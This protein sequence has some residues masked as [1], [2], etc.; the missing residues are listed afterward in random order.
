MGRTQG[1]TFLH[2]TVIGKKQV[3]ILHIAGFSLIP[4]V[5]NQVNKRYVFHMIEQFAVCF[6]T[7]VYFP[8]DSRESTEGE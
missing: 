5:I 4:I 3:D 1:S 7:M 8:S 2:I 6:P